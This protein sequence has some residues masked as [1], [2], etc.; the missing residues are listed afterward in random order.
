MAKFLLEARYAPDGVRGLVGSGAKRRVSTVKAT[1]KELGGK[2][3]AF[4][5]ALG[6]VDAYLILDLP[7]AAAATALALAVNQSGVVSVRT[8]ALLTPD[9]VDE[10][11]SRHVTYRPPC[12]DA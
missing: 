12:S 8:I 3:E 10:A 4:Y 11:I 9:D 6:E 7:D 1:A 5:F 2:V